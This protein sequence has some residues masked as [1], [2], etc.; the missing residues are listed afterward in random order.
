MRV[1]NNIIDFDAT[2]LSIPTGL[3]IRDEDQ[4]A[5]RFRGKWTF[6][7]K[8]L[9][10]YLS[11]KQGRGFILGSDLKKDLEGQ[12]VVGA[13]LLDFYLN[14]KNRHLIPQKY[15]WKM[16]FFW[17]TIYRDSKGTLYVPC[18]NWDGLW[19]HGSFFWLGHHFPQTPSALS[20]AHNSR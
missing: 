11:E 7:Y 9:R 17:G 15:K 8:D 2:P 3:S 18:M 4:I 13:Q 5:S 10:T 14:K 20:I 19:V 6:N 12:P 16:L 1:S